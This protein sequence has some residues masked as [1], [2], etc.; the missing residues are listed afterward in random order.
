MHLAIE[1]M[2]IEVH[3]CLSVAVGANI[4]GTLD[5]IAFFQLYGGYAD[6][7]DVGSIEDDGLPRSRL[8]TA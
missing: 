8:P 2:K 4:A 5:A 3:F 7:L 6:R 1:K